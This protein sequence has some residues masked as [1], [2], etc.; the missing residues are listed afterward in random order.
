MMGMHFYIY[1]YITF[2]F[3]RNEFIVIFVL[4]LNETLIIAKSKTFYIRLIP[5]FRVTYTNFI[6]LVH[7]YLN[8]TL[9]VL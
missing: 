1:E 4:T 7:L 8:F 9:I 6:N 2:K 3:K 5:T